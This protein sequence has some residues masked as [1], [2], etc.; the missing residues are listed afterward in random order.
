[1]HSFA[2]SPC[3]AVALT[4][5]VADRCNLPSGGITRKDVLRQLN[6]RNI[7]E[8]TVNRVDR[9][10]A[11]FEAAQYGVVEHASV[12]ELINRARVCVNELERQKL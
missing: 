5:Y 9:L 1:M 7:R 3:T 11:E 10:L 8:E 6:L 12:N 4:G 2:G